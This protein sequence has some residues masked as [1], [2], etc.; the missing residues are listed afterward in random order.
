[1]N[2]Y[3]IMQGNGVNEGKWAVFTK[4]GEQVSVRYPTEQAA[5]RQAAIMM[6]A[7]HLD[8]WMT[9]L[10]ED[11]DVAE[12]V[13]DMLGL[14]YNDENI[15]EVLNLLPDAMHRLANTYA[16]EWRKLHRVAPE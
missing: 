10:V 1:M 11:S 2:P 4:A 14:E 13:A 12:D 15:G 3:Q 5:R 6:W 9:T 8:V 7:T 16:R